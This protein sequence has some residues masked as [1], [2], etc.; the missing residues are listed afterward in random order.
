MNIEFCPPAKQG[1]EAVEKFEQAF[2]QKI[3][4][5]HCIAVNSGYTALFLTLWAMGIREGD[6]VIVPNFTMV[7]TANAVLACGAH[8]VFVDVELE[9]GNISAQSVEK[10][11][12]TNTKAIIPVHIYGHPAD[13]DALR[14]VCGGRKIAII[15]DAAEAHGAEYKGKKAGTLADAGCFSFYANKVISTGEGGAI[16]TDDDALASELRKLRSYSFA[17]GYLHSGIGWSFRMNPYGA[18][19]GTAEIEYMDDIIARKREIAML[20]SKQ[21][22]MPQFDQELNPLPLEHPGVKSVYWMYGIRTDRKKKLR[23]YL[24]KC[25]IATREFFAPMDMQPHLRYQ[26]SD[27]GSNAYRLW[28]T[29]VLLPSMPDLTNE[30]LTYICEK[31]NEFFT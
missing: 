25:G 6:E 31:I 29:G 16:T 19:E 15:E 30:Q 9:T 14:L 12:T 8:P 11:I 27:P 2:A 21:L 26:E 18:R 17:E 7:A 20:Y 3:G 4:V 23:E 5:K 10:A 1:F 22:Q 13:M 24:E 28:R